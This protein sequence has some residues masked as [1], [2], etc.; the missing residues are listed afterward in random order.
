M[1]ME[2]TR[3][4]FGEGITKV[5]K[6]YSEIV[7]LSAD[8]T[9][10]TRASWFREEYPERFFC[11]GVAEQDMMCTASGFA[12]SGKIPFACTFGVFASGRAWD[13]VRV[14]ICGM[15]LNVNIIG[16]HGG[17][18]VGA[19][20][21]T[22]Q[23]L[24]EISIMRS[25]PNM[26]VI[27]PA[28]SIEARKATIQAVEYPGPIYIRLGRCPAPV[29]TKEKDKF[30]I[31]EANI[32]SRG[33]DITIV[34]CGLMVYEAVRAKDTLKEEGIN[35]EVINLHTV[36][37]IDKKKII[38]S[39]KKTNAVITVEEHTVVGGMGSAVSEVLSE[40]YPVLVKKIGMPDEFGESGTPLELLDKYGLTSKNIVKTAKG[41]VK[42]K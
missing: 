6:S 26:S 21:F 5:G 12:L 13:Q 27:V 3:D 11:F 22:H 24:E 19:D 35:A 34:A 28:D 23:A 29:V 7:V 1:A 39:A 30:K 36:K 38:K 37:P 14:S 18:S 2:P 8:L 16:T 15:N 32:C 33:E 9:S 41:L 31:G 20:G 4:G 40:N 17:I 25:L 10:S 42:K